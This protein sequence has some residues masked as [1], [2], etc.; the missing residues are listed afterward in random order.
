MSDFLIG[1]LLF[2]LFAVNRWIYP[3]DPND[4]HVNKANDIN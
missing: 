3:H 1:M 4:M 2:N